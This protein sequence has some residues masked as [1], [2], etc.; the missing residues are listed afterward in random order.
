MVRVKDIGL[1]SVKSARVMQEAVAS[2]S[3]RPTREQSLQ[4]TCSPG[5]KVDGSFCGSWTT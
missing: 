5:A 1:E 2:R 4:I 3:E